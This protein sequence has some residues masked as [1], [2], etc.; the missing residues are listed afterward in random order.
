[1]SDDFMKSALDRAMERANQIEIPEEKL[2]EME[3]RSQGERLAAGFF[4][5]PDYNI[6]TALAKCTPEAR[7]YV[8]KALETILLKNLVLPKKDSDMPTNEKVFEG[9]STLKKNETAIGQAREQLDNLSNYYTQAR[10]QHYEQL[11]AQ[12]EQAMSQQIQ[13]QTGM[14]PGGDFSVEQR[15]EFQ[16]NWRKVSAQLDAQ[17]DTAL[18]QLKEQI[19]STK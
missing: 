3:Y 6:E 11:K 13:Q 17:Y 18:A 9:L 19:A 5:E 15:P 14:A 2:R 10:K 16:E 12:V 8:T 1:M 4:K 7:Q